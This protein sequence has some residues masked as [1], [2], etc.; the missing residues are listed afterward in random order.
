MRV[1]DPL[2]PRL[3]RQ[4]IAYAKAHVPPELSECAKRELQ[5]FYLQ[6]RKSAQEQSIDT[7]PITTRQ[8]ESLIRLSEARARAVM[9]TV[10]TAEDA[11][12]VIEIMQ[13]SMIETL[14]DECGTLDLGRA[15][16]MSRSRDARKF[17][18]ALHAEAR[19][20]R[21]ALFDR[22]TLRNVAENIGI[23]GE[24]FETLVETVNYQGYLMK[25]GVRKWELQG[26]SFT[27]EGPSGGNRTQRYGGRTT[28]NGWIQGL[29]QHSIARRQRA[30]QCKG[31]GSQRHFE[32]SNEYSPTGSYSESPDCR[33]KRWARRHWCGNI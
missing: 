32:S 7:T 16:G 15:S 1:S 20:S 23:S 10:V 26:S 2:P 27:D 5:E 30:Q 6:L 9:R 3:F 19:R 18:T 21:S 24:R 31:R 22:R 17:I 33:H 14:T 13:E 11:R 4:Y 12:D 8:L 25:K 29:S 28:E